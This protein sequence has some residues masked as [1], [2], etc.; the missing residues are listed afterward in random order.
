MKTVY[1]FDVRSK[2]GSWLSATRTWIQQHCYNGSDVTWGS[3]E[4]L[5]PQMSVKAVEEI[6][7]E[8]AAAVMTENGILTP[9]FTPKERWESLREGILKNIKMIDRDTPWRENEPKWWLEMREIEQ[10]LLNQRNAN[11]GTEA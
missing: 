4:I 2:G 8:A 1:G 3:A 10:K 5:K 6:G 11:K 7:A 9:N